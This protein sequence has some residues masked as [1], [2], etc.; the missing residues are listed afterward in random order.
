MK[1]S[2]NQPTLAKAVS[3]VARAVSPRTTLPVLANIL[4]SAHGNQLRLAATNREIGI[5]CWIAATVE[6]DGAITVPARLLGEFVNS[7]PPER[8]D[9]ELA[10]RTQ[11]LELR[12]ARYKA[13]MSGIDY[14]E[15]PL[16]PTFADQP[17]EAQRISLDAVTLTTMISGVVVAASDDDNR[18]TLTGVEVTI[19][20]GQITMAATDGY[21]LGYR[22]KDVALDGDT[23]TVVI[24]H[25]ALEALGKFLPD[26]AGSVDAVITTK[27]DMML[28]SWAGTEKAGYQRCEMSCSL[29]DARFPDYMATVPKNYKVM[30][31]V[32]TA[33]L[34]EAIKVA[35]LF[36]RDNANI[37]TFESVP[38]VDGNDGQLV[39]SATSAEM[40]ATESKVP[41]LANDAIKIAFNGKLIQDALSTI[42]GPQTTVELTQATR[43]GLFYGGSRSDGFAVIMPMYR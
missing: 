4:L 12:C 5:T 17:E 23:V 31:Q 10:D 7:L 19:G 40:G 38:D 6:D 26:A 32:D 9:M 35:M 27:R 37:V 34:V 1:L 11:R 29:L 13:H 16:L 30:W 14:N 42:G 28:F 25:Q 21:R 43:P 24:P 36:A 39:I 33:K 8:I 3:I 15:F 41:C 20:A 2:V 18:P 22:R